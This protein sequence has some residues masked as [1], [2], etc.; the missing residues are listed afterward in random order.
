MKRTIYLCCLS[1]VLATC[2][3]SC[4]EEM[5]YGSPI[6]TLE[7]DNWI[8]HVYAGGLKNNSDWTQQQLLENQK[9][10]SVPLDEGTFEH[11]QYD[12]DLEG[13]VS[14][15]SLKVGKHIAT[16]NILG[17]TVRAD[18]NKTAYKGGASYEGLAEGQELKISGR[19]DGSQI[20]ASCIELQSDGRDDYEIK[21][22]IAAYDNDGVALVLQNGVIAGPY[23][24][25]DRIVLDIPADP[26]GL[27]VEVELESRDG[28]VEVVH[29]ESD[30]DNHIWSIGAVR[31]SYGSGLSYRHSQITS[32][33]Y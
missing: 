5:S 20:V 23:P 25:S 6:S 8:K 13:P 2:V 11:A 3:S 32:Y 7:G 29:I 27:F 14:A 28:T 18:I 30:A 24:L 9:L 19:F 33:E 22:T 4:G 12:G 31:Y 1:V 10:D 15:E 16:F 21:G 17:M 26:V